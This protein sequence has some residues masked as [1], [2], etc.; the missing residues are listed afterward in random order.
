[1]I[2]TLAVGWLDR[3]KGER[4]NTYIRLIEGNWYAYGGHGSQVYSI[5]ADS[6]KEGR[7]FAT[8]TDAGIK[9]VA[10]KSPTRTAAYQK[11]RRNGTYMGEC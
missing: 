1:M 2:I 3:Q 5:G 8:R 7:W 9:Y 6:P 4:M 11:A 10:T